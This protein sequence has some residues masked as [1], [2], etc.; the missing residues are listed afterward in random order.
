M[1]TTGTALTAAGGVARDLTVRK[2]RLAELVMHLSECPPEMAVHA[3]QR[4]LHARPVDMDEALEVVAKALV[5]VHH[6]VDLRDE[7]LEL[8]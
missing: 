2:S 5:S 8:G 1:Q 4:S 6:G 7:P 3:V